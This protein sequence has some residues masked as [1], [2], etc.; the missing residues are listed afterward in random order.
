MGQREIHNKKVR[1]RKDHDEMWSEWF[2]QDFPNI[3]FGLG[4]KFSEWKAIIRLRDNGWKIK[5]GEE[6]M[7]FVGIDCDG[8]IY[9]G[10]YLIEIQDIV[11]KYD[12][13]SDWDIC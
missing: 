2:R 11:L 1:V 7:G 6:C 4:L 12:L 8:G 3:L 5:K 10:Y 13:V 9:R